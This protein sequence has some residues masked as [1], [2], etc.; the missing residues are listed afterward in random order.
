VSGINY[1]LIVRIGELDCKRNDDKDPAACQVNRVSLSI[2]ELYSR[3]Y[4]ENV[5]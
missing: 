3:I 5:I 4:D 2:T 1:R